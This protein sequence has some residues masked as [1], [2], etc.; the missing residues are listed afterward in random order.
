MQDFNTQGVIPITTASYGVHQRHDDTSSEQFHSGHRE[1][2]TV[3]EIMELNS[4]SP[5]MFVFKS[6]SNASKMPLYTH[7]LTGGIALGGTP[8]TVVV[9]G[10]TDR[11][12]N[13][14][15]MQVLLGTDKSDT[16]LSVSDGAVR[17]TGNN[18]VLPIPSGDALMV[19]LLRLDVEP[20]VLESILLDLDEEVLLIELSEAID[21]SG[22]GALDITGIADFFWIPSQF[23]GGCQ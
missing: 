2:D 20:P 8:N 19:S 17:D 4:Y 21:A 15:K 11:D 10:L 1:R 13:A 22:I 14:I 12:I 3:C 7:T 5:E 16:F 9:V 18:S 6:A 23:Y